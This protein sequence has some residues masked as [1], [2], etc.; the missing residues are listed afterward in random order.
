M[1]K[2]SKSEERRKEIQK[3]GDQEVISTSIFEF[4][5]L[6][7]KD[8]LCWYL[9]LLLKTKLPQA[10]REYTMKISLNEEP[11]KMRIQD[12]EKKKEEIKADKQSE[13]FPSESAK[14][15]QLKNID[16]E[17]KNVEKELEEALEQSSVIEFEASLEK[18][19]YKDGDTLIVTYIPYEVVEPINKI[20]SDLTRHYKIE[21]LRE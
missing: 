5:E 13:L 1:K 9:K 8:D 18:L 17:I 2:D 7:L 21:L 14:K 16:E 6:K 11:F 15:V 10:Y 12:L 20:K 19:E 4:K 3:K